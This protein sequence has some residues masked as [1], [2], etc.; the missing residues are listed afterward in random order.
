MH[1]KTLYI[2]FAV[3]I[4]AV[5]GGSFYGGMAYKASQTPQR[6]STSGFR[7]SGRFATG[8]SFVSGN[9]IAK[10]N[11]SITVKDRSGSSRII[12]Y[13]ATT[14]VGKFV[15]G[16]LNDIQVGQTVMASGK[17]NSDGSISATSIQIRP[18][19]PSATTNSTGQ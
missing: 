8:N 3:V 7:N 14:E 19:L 5:A 1:K 2:I 16:A 17:T 9:I 4:L 12:F 11:Q 6:P 15:T 13:S 10:D 18:A